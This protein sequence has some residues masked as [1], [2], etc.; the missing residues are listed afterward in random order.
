M[1]R[2]EG[3]ALELIHLG[4]LYSS[5]NMYSLIQAIDELI[6]ESKLDKHSVKIT[7]LGDIYGEMKEHHL[8]RYYVK[9]KD[10]LPRAEA[11]SFAASKHISLLVQ[12]ADNR[13]QTTIPYKTYDY[14]NI[15][16]PILG[17]TNSKELSCLLHEHGHIAVDIN[18]I[19]AIKEAIL[20]LV[21]NYDVFLKKSQEIKIDI[22]AQTKEILC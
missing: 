18:D 21:N 9:Q 19:E 6:E 8:A 2:G 4:T 13:S 5:R 16:N 10:I 12:H 11:V 15:K 17:L 3:E 22:V 1:N 14:M 7:N 20:D